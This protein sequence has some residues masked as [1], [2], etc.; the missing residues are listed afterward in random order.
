MEGL[1]GPT[2]SRGSDRVCFVSLVA[3]FSFDC[4]EDSSDRARLWV[5]VQRGDLGLAAVRGRT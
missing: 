3:L 2:S 1:L 4:S 5:G